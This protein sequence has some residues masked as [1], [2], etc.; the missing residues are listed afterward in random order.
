MSKEPKTHESNPQAGT[1]EADS[2]SIVPYFGDGFAVTEVNGRAV[3]YVDDCEPLV[4]R[5][6]ENDHPADLLESRNLN[7]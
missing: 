3:I 4:L 1:E 7:R 2:S 6:F 5:V